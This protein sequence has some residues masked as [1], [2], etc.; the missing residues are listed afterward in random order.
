MTIYTNSRY[1]NQTVMRLRADNGSTYPTVFRSTPP[2]ARRFLHYTIKAGDRYD[3]LAARYYS[4]PTLWW[5]I[6]DANP[7]I[8]YPTNLPIGRVIRIPQQ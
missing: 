7:E 2:P 5:V 4:D 6:A 8:P 3:I 1:A